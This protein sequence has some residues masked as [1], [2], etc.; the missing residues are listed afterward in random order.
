[1]VKLGLCL[2]DRQDGPLLLH[3]AVGALLVIPRVRG[4]LPFLSIAY[5]FPKNFVLHPQWPSRKAISKHLRAGLGQG[6]VGRAWR[7]VIL[8]L[9][10]INGLPCFAICKVI[11]AIAKHVNVPAPQQPSHLLL[12]VLLLQKLPLL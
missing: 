10:H 1:M 7:V 5:P 8:M 9:G 2:I 11:P 6:R 12:V 4:K 3:L